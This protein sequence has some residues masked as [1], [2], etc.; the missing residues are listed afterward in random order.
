[1]RK[2]IVLGNW[3]MNGTLAFNDRLLNELTGGVSASGE[4]CEVAVCVP[5]LYV[6]QVRNAL[7]GSTVR[8]GV[9]DISAH[10][11]GAYTG[12][13]SS[14]MASEFNAAYALVGHSERRTYHR[15]TSEAVGTKA[16]RC[17][18]T[19]IT[20]VVCVG[21]TL[22]ERELGETNSIVERQLSAVLNSLTEEQASRIVVAYE[23]VWAIGT[24]RSASADQAQEVHSF[25]RQVLDTSSSTLSEVSILYGGSVKASTARELF[26]QPD[27]DGVLV[28]G[29]SLDATEFVKIVASVPQRLTNMH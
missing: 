2:Q 15:E 14:R 21:E 16:L 26:N 3:K 19:G 11:E 24:G 12:E 6:P 18:E 25:L 13:I 8:W 7:A 4:H 27:I 5:F 22:T 1:M 23:P 9:Q 17:I 28:G 29:A 20:P 10:A